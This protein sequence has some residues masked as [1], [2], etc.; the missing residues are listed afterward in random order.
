VAPHFELTVPPD[1]PCGTLIPFDVLAVHSGGSTVSSFDL[2]VGSTTLV[3]SSTDTPIELPTSSGTPTV[4]TLVIDDQVTAADVQAAVRIRHED[5]GELRVVLTSPADV[6]VT[7]HNESGSGSADLDAVYDAERL[8]DGPGG[9]DFFDDQSIEGVW[10]L[11]VSDLVPGSPITPAGTLEE[12][13]LIVRPA[14]G[15]TCEPLEC[16]GAPVSDPVQP[17]MRV[18]LRGA[19]LVFSWPALPGADGYRVWRSAGPEFAREEL[20][21]ET[22]G[23]SLVQVDGFAEPAN[24]Y[25]R[26]RA[27]NSCNWEG[28]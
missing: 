17:E 22:A 25:Y 2:L 19:D 13:S 12:W 18:E 9:M 11:R 5:I 4:S 3:L 15:A 8:P 7:L 26:V 23:L 28:P 20:V 14:S 27:V 21:G 6:A 10:T 16:T 1:V 24:W